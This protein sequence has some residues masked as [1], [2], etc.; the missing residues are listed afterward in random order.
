MDFDKQSTALLS[1]YKIG[2]VVP[3]YNEESL[4]RETIIGIP[5]YVNRIYIIDDC[6]I[7]NTSSIVE[8]I[9]DPRIVL[10]RNERNMGVGGA[11]SRGYKLALEDGMD[12]VAV[13]AGDNQMDPEQLPGLIM[14]IIE[15]RADYT[16][17]NRLLNARYREGMS[18]WRTIGNYMLTLLNMVASGYW[19]LAD[20]QNG[21]TAISSKALKVLDLDRLYQRYAFEN[22][23]LVKLNLYDVKVVNIPIPARYGSER[24][25]IKY[26]SFIVRT[27][28]YFCSALVWRV[29]NKYIIK[30]HPIGLLYLLGAILVILGIL[31]LLGSLNPIAFMLGVLLFLIAITIEIIRDTKIQQVAKD[32]LKS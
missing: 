20:P 7:D 32:D 24:S 12:I 19:H 9:R 17:G 28:L 27:S 10:V 18:T 5:P 2:V 25:K 21:Y 31:M 1:Q 16:K 13:M 14:P 8:S 22:D 11:I 23:I 30:L 26:T 15:G 3:A 6:S 4:I 29:W